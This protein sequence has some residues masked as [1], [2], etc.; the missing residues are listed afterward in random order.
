M[1][2]VIFL[3][4]QGRLLRT[5]V[6]MRRNLADFRTDGYD[7]GRGKVTQILWLLA[8]GSVFV[9]WWCPAR[10]RVA[11]LRLF[12]AE[13][14]RDVLVRHRV[15]IHW[16]WKLRIGDHTWVGEGAWLLNLEPIILGA[17]VCISQEA[18]L[19]AGSHNWRS[20][21]FE[22]D[23]APVRVGDGSWVAARAVILRGASV[24]RNCVI[25]AA[26]VVS[27]DV[28]DD[29]VLSSGSVWPRSTEKVAP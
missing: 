1:T 24:G 18:L 6:A 13:I 19:C 27:R 3:D 9:R 22:F 14:G 25:G 23:N 10:A 12:G 7:V 15:R 20:P 29:T 28:P 16:P 5:I 8:S 21:S 2:E 4:S 17:D 26:T 11:M